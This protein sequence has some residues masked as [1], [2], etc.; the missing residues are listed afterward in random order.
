MFN[1]V[2]YAP[3]WVSA[4]NTTFYKKGTSKERVFQLLKNDDP[5]I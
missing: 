3:L 1:W 2:L 4:N 5:V